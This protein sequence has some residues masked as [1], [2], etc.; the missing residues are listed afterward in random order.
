L[1]VSS[2]NVQVGSKL[3]EHRGG[4][5]LGKDVGVLGCR[6]NMTYPNVTEGDPLPNKME[7]NLNVLRALMLD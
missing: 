3:L 7:I 6:R 5:I 1:I 4:K 2:A